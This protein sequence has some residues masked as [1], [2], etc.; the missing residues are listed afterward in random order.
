MKKT[1]LHER[2]LAVVKYITNL[3]KKYKRTLLT[4][5]KDSEP[6]DVNVMFPQFGC[7][8]IGELC[9]TQTLIK[10]AGDNKTKFSE[11]LESRMV[12]KQKTS[13]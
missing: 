9:T 8:T 2:N 3:D 11:A 4:R 7:I 10:I 1:L 13:P 5:A 6:K 12:K